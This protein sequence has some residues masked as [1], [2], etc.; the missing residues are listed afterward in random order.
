MSFLLSAIAFGLCSA[1]VLIGLPA[2]SRRRS[3]IKQT[4]ELGSFQHDRSSAKFFT[5]DTD[6][7]LSAVGVGL[8]FA[9]VSIILWI[10]LGISNL[11]VILFSL[12]IALIGILLER[13]LVLI[14][15][16]QISP[17]T[18]NQLEEKH[19]DKPS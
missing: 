13:D 2:W 11:S 6:A 10:R 19:S 1:S 16:K 18:P 7:W 12:I 9:A 17:R 5:R 15:L 14:G 4:A 8:L 3:A